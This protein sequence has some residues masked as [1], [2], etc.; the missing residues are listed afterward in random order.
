MKNKA[1]YFNIYEVWNILILKSIVVEFIRKFKIFKIILLGILLIGCTEEI[2]IEAENF[3]SIIVVESTITDQLKNQSLKLSRTTPLNT[4]ESQFEMGAIVTVNDGSI[5]YDF[6]QKGNGL[7]VSDI[8]FAATENTD[9]Q[10]NITTNDGKNYQSSIVQLAAKAEL[11]NVFV[12]AGFSNNINGAQIFVD[13]KGNDDGIT[14]L[15]YEFEETYKIVTPI[16][17][18]IE[19]EIINY[20]P[21]FDGACPFYEIVITPKLFDT[22]ICYGSNNSSGIVQ[23]STSAIDNN[24]VRRVPVHFISATDSKLRERYSIL[25]KQYSQSQEAFSFYKIIN[26]LGSPESLLSESQPGFVA[27]NISSQNDSQEKVLG[28][29]EISS[30]SEKRIYFN[31]QDIDVDR[32]LYFEVNCNVE[33][34]DYSI[35]DPF[36]GPDQ[37]SPLFT[38]VNAQ[39]FNFVAGE[40]PIYDIV[41]SRCTDCTS[42][43]TIEKPDFWID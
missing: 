37:R 15:R 36:G 5:T 4:T 28:F 14:Y 39:F 42:L 1:K 31:F 33:S 34:Y 38:R 40:Y 12:D 26:D 18:I 43:G 29:F 11:V 24:V 27:G 41:K 13:S 20:D 23:A 22:S 8:P 2:D 3:E 30:Y 17:S 9:Y 21:F 10:L 32:P 7:Y 35:C 19:G 6:S 25:V 16:R